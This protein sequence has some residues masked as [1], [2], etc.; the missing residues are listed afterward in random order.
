MRAPMP[1]GVGEV[2]MIGWNQQPPAVSVQVRLCK[3]V[4]WN[5]DETGLVAQSLVVSR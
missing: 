2:A 5:V 1:S 3:T 4:K